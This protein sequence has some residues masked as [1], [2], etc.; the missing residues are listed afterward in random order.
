MKR[1]VFM[2]CTAASMIS[3]SI[4]AAELQMYSEGG[5]E[6]TVLKGE[7]VYFHF[8]L[9]C[10]GPGWKYFYMRGES[11]IDGDTRVFDSDAK[12]GGTD[13]G[14]QLKHRARQ[15]GE[16]SVAMGYEL[17]VT[18]TAPLTQ[19]CAG[20]V[21]SKDFFAGTVCTAE[22]SG[23]EKKEISVPLGRGR[24]SDS[25]EALTFTDTDGNTIRI[26][27]KPP[28]NCSMDGEGR[29]AL[30]EEQMAA[31]ERRKT[32]L[33]LL[34]SEGVTFHA[35]DTATVLRDD[36]TDWFPYPTGPAGV[37]VDLSFLNKDKNGH[38]I[39]A[40]THG[41]LT[42][43]DGEFVFEDGTPVKFWGVNCTAYAVLSSDERAEQ[44]AERVARMGCNIV[45]LHHLDSWANPI[46]DY[47][48]PDGTTQHLNPESMR[49]LDKF[50]YEMKKRGIYIVLD[51]WVQRCF[52]EAD[53][54][55]EYGKR[56]KRG[57]F[58]L[59]PFIYFDERMQELI[60][61]QWKQVWTHVNEYTGKAYIDEPACAMTEVINEGLM[62]GLSGVKAPVYQERLRKRY[63]AWA[64]KNGGIPYEKANIIKQNFG[65]NN[66]RFMMH[67][68]RTYYR[69][70]YDYLRRI[71]VRVP[72][73]MNNWA[74]WTWIMAAQSDGDFMDHHHYYGGDQVGPGSGLGGLWVH[75]PPHKPGTPFGKM[76]GYALPGKPI[77]S[78]ENGN[79]PPKTYRSSYSLGL[80]AV[81]CLQDWDS[82]TGY[83]YSQSS[84]PQETL[85][86]FEWESD[87]AM[88]AGAAAGALVFRRRDVQPAKQVVAFQLDEREILTLR[89]ENGGEKQYWNTAGFNA[90]IEEHKVM[91]FLPGMD[92]APYKP[93][94]V[95]DVESSFA[96]TPPSTELRS[97]TGELW[98]DW[99]MGVGTMDTPRT[100][101][102]YGKLGE[103]GE[104]WTTRDCTFRIST[105]YAVASLSS[106]TMDP[107][108]RSEKILLTAV[109]RTQNSGMAFN[110]SRSKIVDKGKA[111]IIAEPV[112]GTIEM[113]TR[114]KSL[115]M[116]PLAV[117]G[118]R[119]EGIA[120]PVKNGAAS[121]EL[122]T[123][124]RTIFYEIEA[125]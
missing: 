40:G 10:W 35:D 123:D 52:K 50:V 28:R 111:P 46:I 124:Y 69:K 37:P 11:G 114:R 97:E 48:H 67:L 109:A 29:I 27:I 14:I 108:H 17:S 31:G 83:A 16:R 98:R 49:L 44:L 5:A 22:L 51:P 100:Q 112:I 68:Q 45:R 107:L 75:H 18:E 47:D 89:Y 55:P 64:A 7:Q 110:M 13:K 81:A 120:I 41:F 102:A 96:Y 121:I 24:I 125:K 65:D 90:A 94:K 115:T 8:E 117:D 59:H 91:V 12:I 54:V 106:L 88:V 38:Y 73:N 33:T 56:G 57:N 26:E 15:D 80:A 4:L 103:S 119:K 82:F 39:P 66:I 43:K 86:A 6:Y 42:V 62:S 23:G 95:L 76:A 30:A 77:K 71:G 9:P 118:T 63:D 105:P 32:E 113:K 36:T 101:A 85:A 25:V 92:P 19:I 78:S 116:Y 1:C 20:L 60:E 34:F 99:K 70:S 21:P 2:A 61:K 74:H 104:V 79:N 53:G 84:R 3:T 72:I 58:N 93:I 87:P 122:K